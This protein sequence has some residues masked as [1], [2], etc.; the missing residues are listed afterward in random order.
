MSFVASSKD[1]LSTQLC[2]LKSVALVKATTREDLEVFDQRVLLISLFVQLFF[3]P[4]RA[5]KLIGDVNCR[6]ESYLS[7]H[8]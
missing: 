4:K 8:F 3:V 1:A 2:K 6:C 7:S 5:A